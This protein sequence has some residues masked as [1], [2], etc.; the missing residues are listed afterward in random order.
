MSDFSYTRNEKGCLVATPVNVPRG[1]E[2]HLECTNVPLP[3][4]P[5]LDED[6]LPW[7]GGLLWGPCGAGKSYTAIREL[8]SGLVSGASAKFIASGPYIQALRDASAL[9]LSPADEQ[10]R[11][12]RSAAA[13]RYAVIDDL[14]AEK[15]TDYANEQLHLLFDGRASKALPT[16]V[17]ANLSIQDIAAV[18]GDRIASRILGFS[19]SEPRRLE[20][21]DRR[22]TWEAEK[23]KGRFLRIATPVEGR[24]SDPQ[25]AFLEDLAPGRTR[26]GDPK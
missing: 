1:Y 21:R 9:K 12:L 18:H 14:G 6:P 5:A 20:G 13:A 17:T 3:L 24:D 25:A 22:R 7:V 23:P 8:R 19:T 26:N 2:S 10:V 11:L 4:L 16:L 15:L